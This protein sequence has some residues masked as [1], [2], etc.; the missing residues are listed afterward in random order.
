L[1]A[2][3]R[4]DIVLSSGWSE[5]EFRRLGDVVGGNV[6]YRT[7]P[8][9][10]FDNVD[11]QD[12][13]VV[14]PDAI[15]AQV[16]A[17][18]SDDGAATTTTAAKPSSTVDVINAGTTTGLAATI[19]QDL[20]QRGY[21]GG[22]VRN[23]FT[24]E[25]R[26]TGISYGP[27]AADDAQSLATLLGIK[28]SPQLDSSEEPGHIRVTIG[29][30]YSLPSGFGQSDPEPS[31]TAVPANATDTSTDAPPDQGQPLGGGDVPCVN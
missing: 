18:F 21:T 2:V 9:V 7:L 23:P 1:I 10:R 31:A 26:A 12:V 24:G 3:A 8:I 25:S 16:A 27:G 19:S 13:N 30:D 28:A 5:E 6:Q 11:G 14:D 17:A 29:P 20:D 22:E 15:K 4:K